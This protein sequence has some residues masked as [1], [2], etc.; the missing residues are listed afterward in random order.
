MSD[1]V[2]IMV[3]PP[4]QTMGRRR[5]STSTH[6]TREEKLLGGV[7]HKM[8][9]NDEQRGNKCGRCVQAEEVH[10]GGHLLKRKEMKGYGGGSEF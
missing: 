3:A 2:A 6:R 8:R 5:R 10:K 7:G 4:K 9:I 1:P